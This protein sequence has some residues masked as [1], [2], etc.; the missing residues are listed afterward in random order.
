MFVIHKEMLTFTAY[1][2]WLAC[3][4]NV[5]TGTFETIRDSKIRFPSLILYSAAKVRT[6][7]TLLAFF[8]IPCVIVM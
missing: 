7:N 2:L 1:K 6:T 3:I 4:C 8:G 5:C